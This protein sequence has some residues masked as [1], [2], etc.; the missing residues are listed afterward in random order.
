MVKVCHVTS[1][2]NSFD[3]RVFHK[4]CVSLAAGGFEVYLVAPGEDREDHGV[5]VVGIGEKPA[6]TLNRIRSGF[7]GKAYQKALSLDCE[8]YHIHDPEL[9]P[10]ALRLK[11]R[12]KTVIFDSHEFYSLLLEEKEYVPAALRKTAARIYAA[13][14]TYILRRLDAVIT[15]CTVDGRNIFEGRA[16]RIVFIDNL[17]LPEAIQ[18]VGTFSDGSE[19]TVGYL[20]SISRSR[21]I[22]P[23]VKACHAANAKLR[24]A[25]SVWPAYLEELKAMP[26][27]S[28][29]E[30]EGVLSI[31]QIPDFCR[32]IRVGMATL[33]PVGQYARVDNL[34]TK[35]YEYLGAGLP[36]IISNNRP[37]RKLA[38]E[39]DCCL[40]VDPENIE[41]VAAAIRDLLDDPERAGSM[42]ERGYKAVMER[43]SWAREAEKL[44]A[45]YRELTV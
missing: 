3:T 38:E 10:Y 17:P 26:E 29:V 19:N 8:I 42:G 32:R 33:L 23:L 39:F 24:L 22:G 7:P 37:G 2:H 30:Y 25:G 11:K 21:G 45:L 20:G 44:L 41:E 28:C 43:Y 9:L 6:G 4:E 12:G 34:P 15:P 13:G 14:E 1:A 31:G 18:G 40:C 36:V 35:V 27:Y 5:H 16:R